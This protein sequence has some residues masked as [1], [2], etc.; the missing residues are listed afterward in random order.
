MAARPNIAEA[1]EQSKFYL[2]CR[3]AAVYVAARPNIAE[4]PEQSKCF[5]I[6]RIIELTLKILTLSGYRKITF[7]S[8]ENRQT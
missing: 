4:A 8:S 5:N 7:R 3:G 2:L 1:P 6:G